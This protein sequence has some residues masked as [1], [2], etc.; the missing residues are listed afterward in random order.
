MAAPGPQAEPAQPQRFCHIPPAL[1]GLI[2]WIVFKVFPDPERP[3]KL[4]KI[5]YNPITGRHASSTDPSAWVSFD[6]A[7]AAVESGQYD[8]I[9]FAFSEDDDYVGIDFDDVFEDGEFDPDALAEIQALGSYTELTPSGGGFHVIVLANNLPQ[10][11]KKTL[12]D[13]TGREIYSS[14]R[15]FTVTGNHVPGFPTTIEHRQ[16][17]VDEFLQKHFSQTDEDSV[18]SATPT[19][20]VPIPDWSGAE[21]PT[22]FEQDLEWCELE[23]M[24]HEDL[25][26]SDLFGGNMEA[27][28]ND[29]SRA[30]LALCSK[31]AK[32]YPGSSE[33]FTCA[34]V[35]RLFR[36]SKLKRPKWDELRGTNT[37]GQ[38]TVVKAVRSRMRRSAACSPTPGGLFPRHY[39]SFGDFEMKPMNHADNLITGNGHVVMERGMSYVFVG[40]AGA[41]KTTF[42]LFMLAHFAIGRSF[43][44]FEPGRPRRVIVFQNENSEGDLA[45][46]QNGFMD[47]GL[48]DEE[49][50][51]LRENLIVDSGYKPRHGEDGRFLE[52]VSRG[53]AEHDADIAYIDSALHYVGG[54]NN[55]AED[56]G[57]FLRHGL[58]PVVREA[59]CVCILSTHPS[60]P[61]KASDRNASD[62]LWMLYYAS[63]SIEWANFPRNV[64]TM[65]WASED[66][67][68][69]RIDA[70]KNPGR[71]PW[72]DGHTLAVKTGSPALPSWGE[73]DPDQGSVAEQFLKSGAQKGGREEKMTDDQ[74]CAVVAQ[75]PGA[76]PGGLRQKMAELFSVADGT[77]K[78]R[79]SKATKDGHIRR[80]DDGSYEVAST[81][82][83]NIPKR[84]ETQNDVMNDTRGAGASCHS[85]P[86]GG[87]DK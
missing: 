61:P 8:C 40:A 43:F 2:Q 56:V 76:T 70:A 3:E 69:L 26:A 52:I 10:G 6:T 79:I 78:N 51:L 66:K 86:V 11:K 39:A 21:P 84:H 82:E 32:I 18:S 33:E 68:T 85:P 46:I 7:R 15:F 25:V 83:G 34:M 49:M 63:G 62:P 53:V 36:L 64:F 77:A 55:S 20:T 57:N 58:D 50:R 48:S 17:Q 29:H 14:G 35:D 71:S 65:V 5:P 23:D 37:Y 13:D 30:D 74:L 12:G 72:P 41:G 81:G 38:I 19:A 28:G 60:K 75:N 59:D 80:L 22:Q 73:A 4:K 45:F 47:S 87:S 9:G 42:I 44:G 1:I 54:S 67:K 16:D 27:Y 24:L 31:L